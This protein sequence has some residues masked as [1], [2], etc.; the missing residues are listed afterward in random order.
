MWPR[1]Y[2]A[3][4]KHLLMLPPNCS[5]KLGTVFMFLSS[6]GCQPQAKK[7]PTPLSRGGKATPPRCSAL[8]PRPDGVWPLDI[9]KLRISEFEND[10]SS[11]IFFND[12][13]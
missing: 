6:S 3:D 1:S 5:V 9:S 8:N 12:Q 11:D 4:E 7:V 2:L 13:D 10:W